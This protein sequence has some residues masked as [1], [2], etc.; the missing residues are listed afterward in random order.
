MKLEEL[1]WQADTTD[2][3]DFHNPPYFRLGPNIYS[4][5]NVSVQNRYNCNYVYR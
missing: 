1:Q 5:C 2:E 4:S 3:P